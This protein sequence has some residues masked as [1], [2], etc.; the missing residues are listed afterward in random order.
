MPCIKKI[1]KSE[2]YLKP[3]PPHP[4]WLSLV[5]H[6]YVYACVCMHAGESTNI[7]V[8]VTHLSMKHK[9][10]KKNLLSFIKESCTTLQTLALRSSFH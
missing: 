4:P 3:D 6:I 10:R 1:K 5:L 9:N 2:K 7:Y 8:Y